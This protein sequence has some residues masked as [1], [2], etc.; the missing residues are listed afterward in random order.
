MYE[1]LKNLGFEGGRILEPAL[2]IGN[3]FGAM[4][5]D[6]RK[7]SRLYGVELDQIS[8]GIAGKI[9]PEAEIFQKGFEKTSFSDNSFDLVIGNVPFGQYKV[10][11]KAYDAHNF[12]I[13]DYFIAKALDKA[14]P[15]GIVAVIT[16]KGTMDKKDSSARSYFAERADLLGALRLPNTAFKQNA[17]TEVTSDILFFQ[18]RSKPL[19][20]DELPA[21][22][23]TQTKDGMEINRYFASHPEMIV[24]TMKM[25]S[26]P[27]GP[28]SACLPNDTDVPFFTQLQDAASKIKGI[29]T[30]REKTGQ[31]FQESIE[32]PLVSDDS[33]REYSYALI[34]G[35]R[36]RSAC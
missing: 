35:K 13:H 32:K 25:V 17:G 27:F 28:E 24:G 31:D 34:D 16:S 11:D 10:S 26:G 6:L 18:K 5:E 29:Y 3:F 33:I 30:E 22:I 2:G 14:R 8:A 4:P 21:W 9:Y 36:I 19:E 7:E 20:K 1:V 12:L 15:G 23:E